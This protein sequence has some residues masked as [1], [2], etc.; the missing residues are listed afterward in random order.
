M[1]LSMTGFGKAEVT[2]N[3]YQ[4]TI[5]L[6]SLNSKQLELST[7]I[8]SQ[9]KEIEP[10]LRSLIS[11]LVV[12]GKLEFS[13]TAN[14]INEEG[15]SNTSN[16]F[17]FAKITAYYKEVKSI[18]DSLGIACPDD[19][20]TRLITLP[21]SQVTQQEN[22]GITEELSQAIIE[23]TTQAIEGMRQFRSQEGAMIAAIFEEKIANIRYL[24]QQIVPFEQARI[25]RIRQRFVEEIAKLEGVTIDN[26]R[27]AQEII[28][29]IEKLDINE[30]KTRLSNHLNYFLIT[31]NEGDE[32]GVGK[33]LGFIAQEIGREINTLGSKSCNAEM[34]QIVVQMK[35]ELE[36][37]KEQVL[38]IL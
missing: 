11:R 26:N 29:Y 9:F 3:G 35:D 24:L 13:I 33:K 36:Q 12:R 20:L 27:L 22:S 28:Y 10:E 23:A 19:I 37:I 6:R 2:I 17:D 1:I 32:V 5:H 15:N 16:V 31:M 25:E 30:E 18:A 4:V 34:Q 8:P 38:N 21:G 7:R 14:P